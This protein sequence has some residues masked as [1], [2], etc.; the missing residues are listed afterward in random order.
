MARQSG[1]LAVETGNFDLLRRP[2][3][4]VTA[5]RLP[6]EVTPGPWAWDAVQPMLCLPGLVRPTCAWAAAIARLSSPGAKPMV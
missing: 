1:S 6:L 3:H 5:L 4:C 2:R